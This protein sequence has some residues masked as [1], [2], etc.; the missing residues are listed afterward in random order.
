GVKG[1]IEAAAGF[2]CYIAVLL[3]GGWTFGEQLS[4]TN[5]LYMQAITAF[6]SAVVICQIANVFASRTRFQSVFSMGLFSNRLVLLGI[7]SE[8]LIL[9]F[10]IWNPFSN[11]IFNTAPIDLRYMLLAVPFAVLLLGVDELRKYLLRKNVNWV[12]RFFKW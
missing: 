3:E 10:I 6:F 8:L 12:T 11:L 4:N 5:P 1:P 9:A 7:V 2:F